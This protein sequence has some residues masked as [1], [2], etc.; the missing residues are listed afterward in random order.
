MFRRR[1]SIGAA[2]LL[3]GLLDIA[4][5]VVPNSMQMVVKNYTLVI[6]PDAIDR[7]RVNLPAA[8]GY[9]EDAQ[10][11]HGTRSPS[12]FLFQDFTLFP[13]GNTGWH[14]HPGTVLITVAE[15]SVDWYDAECVKHVRS[16]GEFF[17]ESNQ[18]HF[19]QNSKSA[20]SR[21]IITYV[22]AKDLTYK[23]YRPAP[24]CAA[25]LGLR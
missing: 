3:F 1:L 14:I 21:M 15:G 17:T 11:T 8:A 5:A 9:E 6:D 2:G 13:G 24:P 12:V 10:V 25:A 22:I 23:I 7:V 18:L 19:V 4:G 16:A 20:P